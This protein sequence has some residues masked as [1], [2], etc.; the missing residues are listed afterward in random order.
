MTTVT[1]RGKEYQLGDFSEVHLVPMARF[2]MQM[3]K[4][5][6]DKE[7]WQELAEIISDIIVPNIDK[8]LVN[9]E[10]RRGIFL[11]SEEFLALYQACIEQLKETGQLSDKDI[12][13]I[14]ASNQD[15]TDAEI[16]ALKAQIE[17]L[18]AK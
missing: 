10:I 6:I 8:K 14:E 11:T 4:Q 9:P 16:E 17:A 5:S 13:E 7:L 2:F 12:E 15:D 1:L 3:K 18:K